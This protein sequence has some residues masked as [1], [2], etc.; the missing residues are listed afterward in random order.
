[1]NCLSAVEIK[2]AHEKLKCELVNLSAEI[3]RTRTGTRTWGDFAMAVDS[4]VGLAFGL[5][6]KRHHPAVL[7]ISK[8]VGIEWCEADN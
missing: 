7:F 3:G 1:V 4:K 5:R 2:V 8:L 6:V